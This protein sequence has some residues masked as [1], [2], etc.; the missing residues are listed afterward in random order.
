MLR[1][2]EGKRPGGNRCRL[3]ELADGPG[4]SE[5]GPED[6]AE[7]A[8]VLADRRVYG[9]TVIQVLRA[10]GV[11]VSDAQVGHHRRAHVDGWSAK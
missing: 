8:E 4:G 2:Q 6:A 10:R 7:L 1:A 5:L 9:S 11:R 3:C